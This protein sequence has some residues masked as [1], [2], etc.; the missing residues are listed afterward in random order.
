MI[1]VQSECFLRNR[2]NFHIERHTIFWISNSMPILQFGRKKNV[3]MT[4][5]G[6]PVTVRYR[7]YPALVVID[8]RTRQTCFDE[9]IRRPANSK[10]IFS[11][12]G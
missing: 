8:V 6:S 1:R 12:L 11:K 7:G 3:Q 9:G 10:N 5:I 4:P 2:M